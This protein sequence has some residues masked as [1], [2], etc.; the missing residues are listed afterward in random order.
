LRLDEM[1]FVNDGYPVIRLDESRPHCGVQRQYAVSAAA[2]V[3]RLDE[4]RPHCGPCPSS[5]PTARW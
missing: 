1:G 2:A 5:V 3:I 4:S